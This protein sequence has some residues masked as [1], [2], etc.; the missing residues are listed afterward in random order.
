[1]ASKSG[2]KTKKGL[3]I[4]DLYLIAYNLVLTGGWFAI[5]YVTQQTMLTWKTNGDLLS[6]KGLFKNVEF[7]LYVFQTAALMEVLHA[8]IGL[9]RSNPVLVLLQ[10]LSR[11]LVVWLILYFFEPV[12]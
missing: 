8:A 2:E 10:V 12:T 1:M 7:L 9:V 5:L 4:G 6:S 3:S 11:L